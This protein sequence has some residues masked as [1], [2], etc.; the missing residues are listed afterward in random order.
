MQVLRGCLTWGFLWLTCGVVWGQDEGAED[1]SETLARAERRRSMATR[2]DDLIG[3]RLKEAQVSPAARTE[4]AEFLRRAW[5]DLCGVTPRVSDVREFLADQR[6]DKRERLVER[7]LASPAHSNHLANRWREVLLPSGTE[8]E[9]IDRAIGVQ[10]WLRSQFSDNIRYDR[11]VSEFL[12]ARE[13]SEAGPAL[14]YTSLELKPEKLAAATARTFLGVQIE[15][16]QC[17][18]HPFDHWKQEEFWGYAAF[19]ARLRQPRE[20]VM[21]DAR[22]EDLDTGEVT[23]P[24]KDTVIAPRFPGAD[25][26]AP[27]DRGTR[28]EQ[29]AIWMASRDNPYLARAAVNRIWAHLF[30]RGLV[31]PVDDLSPQHPA[32]HPELLDEL[33]RWFVRSGFDQRELYRVLIATETY[34]R[35]SQWE[36]PEMPA[37]ELF[38]RMLEKPLTAEQLYDSLLRLVTRAAGRGVDPTGAENSLRDPRRIAFIAKMQT[39]SRSAT[40]YQAGV[41][42]ALTL[43]NGDETATV[44]HPEQ[45]SLLASLA[46]PFFSPADRVEILFLATL[47]RRPTDEER[48]VFE[49]H[50]SEKSEDRATWA[51]ALW[52]IVNSAEFTLNH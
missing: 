13:G 44:T 49:K 6:P 23:L 4:D 2:I 29:L 50:V 38:A 8:I 30:G 36:G 9:R 12:V 25:V 34:Q 22:I 5:L 51:N 21:V 32:S 10:N 52:A 20:G 39:A 42:Q 43:M 17:H 35:T 11:F 45:G 41:L 1:P 47:S 37:T 28:R 31:E 46:A 18:H 15:C 40:E 24:N 26:D 27:Q 14:F 19:F 16:A 33:T 48:Q 3:A 7:L